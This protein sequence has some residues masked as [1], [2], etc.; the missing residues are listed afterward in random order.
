[1]SRPYSIDL[2]ERVGGE[3]TRAKWSTRNVSFFDG[4]LLLR[5]YVDEEAAVFG[6]A[7]RR[8]VEAG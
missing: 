4:F 5:R 1:M 7:D 3:V 2:R 8:G 6:R